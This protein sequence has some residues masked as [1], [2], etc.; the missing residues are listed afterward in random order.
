MTT[1]T[2]ANVL[3]IDMKGYRQT[4]QNKGKP[5]IL[6]EGLSNAFD[7]KSETVDVAF[8]QKD[9]W[10]D[11]L[12]KDDDPDGFANLRDAWT[13]FAA[14]NR[15]EDAE[16]RGRFGQGEKE[17]IAIAVDG[18]VLTITSTKGSVSFTKE[19][20]IQTNE[21]IPHGTVLVAK[22]KLNQAEAKEFKRLVRSIIVPQ[23]VVFKFNYAVIERP[24]PVATIRETL[25]TVYWDSDGNIVNTRRQT[26][27]ELYEA[28]VDSAWIYELGIPVVEHD[29]RFHIN[30]G[31]KVPLNSARDN[32]TP[33]YLR[34]LREIVLN[35][36]HGLLDADDM[37]SAWVTEALP[38]AT[39]EATRSVVEGIHG[40][41]TVIFDPSNPEA[42]KRAIDEGYTV[43]YG[44]QFKPEAWAKIKEHE[45]VKPA[46]Q[47]IEV[48]IPSS[49]DGVAPLDRALWTEGML[50]L[51]RYTQE[52]GEELLGFSPRVDYMTKRVQGGGGCGAWWGQRHIT[53]NLAQLGKAWPDTASRV[54]VDDLIIHEFA[55]DSMDDHYSDRFIHALSRLGS[56]LRD[57]KATLR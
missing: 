7:T 15:R 23:G 51:E 16:S 11:L 38:Q 28:D 41:R 6:I 2:N 48:G 53:F 29:G 26:D 46:G 25:P 49:P 32:I 17:L 56:K 36:T 3:D 44:R 5:R 55:H 39:A 43:I 24:T 34:K 52:L 37:K 42:T 45:I 1:T 31:Q 47:V 57:C 21:C 10:A 27:I 19:G 14:S 20:R 33:S 18:G 22:L 50:N 40:K 12:I 4:L 8:A 35:E 9:G 13:L 30:V 54:Q